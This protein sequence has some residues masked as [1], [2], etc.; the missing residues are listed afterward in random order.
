MLKTHHGHAQN[1]VPGSFRWPRKGKGPGDEV[2]T[3]KQHN[4]C[5]FDIFAPATRRD[6]QAWQPGVTA[7]ETLKY[8]ANEFFWHI[9]NCIQGFKC[10]RYIFQ[11]NRKSN[12]ENFIMRERGGQGYVTGTTYHRKND[13]PWGAVQRLP[14]KQLNNAK[15]GLI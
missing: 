6:S 7:R 5:T 11:R 15:A 1:L 2:G 14:N 8:F 4:N 3:A 9:D 13:S 12:A 10:T